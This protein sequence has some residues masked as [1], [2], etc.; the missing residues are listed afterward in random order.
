MNRLSLALCL[1]LSLAL[2]SCTVRDQRDIAAPSSPVATTT[3][4]VSGVRY[5]LVPD[6]SWLRLRVYKTGP[7]ARFGHDHVIASGA[8]YGQIVRAPTL[9]DSAFVLRLPLSQLVV[10]DPDARRAEGPEF[11]KDIPEKD[12]AGTKQ[13]MLG[14]KLLNAANFPD[15]VLTSRS[16]SP[17]AAEVGVTVAGAEHVVS[18]P[19]ELTETEDQIIIQG[20]TELTHAQLGLEPFSALGGALRVREDI[21][22]RYYLV[23]QRQ[24]EIL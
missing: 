15:I 24:K 21:G 5:E 23:A 22:L 1:V 20:Q 11:A 10:D 12:R 16:V 3:V 13:N 9:S 8:L 14:D 7:L 4:D 2:G 18:F 6:A 19:Y 17:A